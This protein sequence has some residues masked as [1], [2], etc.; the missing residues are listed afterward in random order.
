MLA[1]LSFTVPWPG[2]SSRRHVRLCTLC[3]VP[4]LSYTTKLS[5]N[6]PTAESWP[7]R[8]IDKLSV[9]IYFRLRLKKF[10][11]PWPLWKIILVIFSFP[12]HSSSIFH[13]NRPKNVHVVVLK[14]Y[15]L[16]PFTTIIHFNPFTVAPRKHILTQ[17]YEF[18]Q[19]RTLTHFWD[20]DY[21]FKSLSYIHVYWHTRLYVGCLLP[22][23]SYLYP[24][25]VP[26]CLSPLTPTLPR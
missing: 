19:L 18:P 20:K 26:A 1:R 22:L 10:K 3:P 15:H 16:T 7:S 4:F 14:Y 11:F 2:F 21:E 8:P 17:I 24:V 25:R 12:S 6:T 9:N 23:P 5:T 13:A